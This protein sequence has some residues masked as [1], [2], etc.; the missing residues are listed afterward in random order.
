M[1]MGEYM[2][3]EKKKKNDGNTTN[4][5]NCTFNN[6]QVH[7]G[8]G[9]VKSPIK[10]L[11]GNGAVQEF[12]DKSEQRHEKKKWGERF[13]KWFSIIADIVTVSPCLKKIFS[14]LIIVI[15]G[16]ISAVSWDSCSYKSNQTMSELPP[17]TEK[18][19]N[20]IIED[21]ERSTEE[22]PE[23]VDAP[24]E[25]LDLAEQEE[26]E[27]FYEPKWSEQV[28]LISVNEI[29]Q[30][31]IEQRVESCGAAFDARIAERLQQVE[32]V[33]EM[34][35]TYEIYVIKANE[36]YENYDER[37]EY[38]EKQAIVL[39]AADNRN[40]AKDEYRQESNEQIMGNYY[41]K[42]GIN[43]RENG[44]IDQEFKYFQN[45]IDYYYDAY[46][47][48]IKNGKEKDSALEY[49][50]TCFYNIAR[51]ENIDKNIK[52]E[53]LISAVTLYQKY[54][55]FP[56]NEQLK[57]N[58]NIG[59]CYSNLCFLT[60]DSADKF[61]YFEKAVEFYEKCYNDSKCGKEMSPIV[62]DELKS[63]YQYCYDHIDQDVYKE[64]ISRDE[65]KKK[66]DEYVKLQE[67]YA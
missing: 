44:L 51:I 38:D 34:P 11:D 59:R 30:L 14:V 23:N 1:N 66:H 67:R 10:D 19:V 35:E 31:P 63:I 20:V 16:A 29:Q 2:A 54:G 6:S 33:E 57:T 55:S 60:E 58:L 42:C 50:A 9:D 40:S 53:A 36:I 52:E 13:L 17:D 8:Q 61:F 56:K 32:I 15:F 4:Y 22:P 43:A 47:V 7:N 5:N 3:K 39:D 49:M 65:I 21:E 37:Y 64:T 46:A 18:E 28:R 62:Y 41:A 27:D 48:S 24:D 45:A 12:D 26:K 25:K